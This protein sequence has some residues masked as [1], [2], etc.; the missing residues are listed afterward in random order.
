MVAGVFVFMGV[1]RKGL[2]LMIR[3]LTNHNAAEAGRTNPPL[4]D[5]ATPRA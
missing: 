2:N 5:D 1:G 3:N 4:D